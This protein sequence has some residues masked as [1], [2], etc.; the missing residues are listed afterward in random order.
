MN[1]KQL[2]VDGL[3]VTR[4]SVQ[5]LRNISLAIDGGQVVALVGPNG[6]GKSTLLSAISRQTSHDGTVLWG[7]LPIAQDK[8]GYMP[9]SGEVRAGLSVLEVVLLGRHDRLRWKLQQPDIE[10]AA[11]AIAALGLQ[12]LAERRIDALSGGQQQLVLLAQRLVRRP[13]LLTLDEATSALDVRHQIRVLDHLAAYARQTASLVLIALHDL[14]LA[15]RYASHLL[16][17]NGGRLVAGGPREHVLTPETIRSAY[18]IDSEVLYAGD[19]LPVIVPLAAAGLRP[20]RHH[21][22]SAMSSSGPRAS[23]AASATR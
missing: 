1:A 6:S 12:D 16:L 23:A 5:I 13:E 3:S 17:L 15:A 8:L 19:G 9:Q 14:N 20:P 2:V 4:R 11:A 7:G 21:G 18:G 22:A 10:A